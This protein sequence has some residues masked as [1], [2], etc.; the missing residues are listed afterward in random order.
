MISTNHAAVVS[1][2]FYG[3]PAMGDNYSAS[4]PAGTQ[5]ATGVTHDNKTVSALPDAQPYL[6]QLPAEIKVIV[7]NHLSFRDIAAL[8]QTCTMLYTFMEEK[9]IA[10]RKCFTHHLTPT[11]QESFRVAANL[12]TLQEFTA[13]L[14]R[15]SDDQ[16]FI[17]YALSVHGNQYFP[18]FLFFLMMQFTIN[19]RFLEITAT[20]SIEYSNAAV[21]YGSFS[22]NGRHILTT[23]SSSGMIHSVNDQGQWEMKMTIPSTSTP[24]SEPSF[25]ANSRHV[26]TAGHPH[27]LTTTGWKYPIEIYDFSDDGK[28][29]KAIA[30]PHCWE[31]RCLSATFFNKS[32]NI[33]LVSGD[34]EKKLTIYGM[35]N[36]GNWSPDPVSSQ[37]FWVQKIAHSPDGLHGVTFQ[38]HQWQ[39]DME[40]STIGFFAISGSDWRMRNEF[41]CKYVYKLVFS[42]DNRHMVAVHPKKAKIYGIDSNGQWEL[43]K[44]IRHKYGDGG[45]HNSRYFHYYPSFHWATFSP[46]GRYLATASMH[47]QKVKISGLHS[48]SYQWYDIT[49]INH[50]SDVNMVAFS[51]DSRHLV[52]GSDDCSAKLYGL[53]AIDRWYLKKTLSHNDAVMCADFS[54]DGSHLVTGCCNGQ[55]KLYGM[56]ADR[57]WV[58]KGMVWS[59]SSETDFKR[60]SSV[61]FSPCGFQILVGSAYGLATLYTLDDAQL[62]GLHV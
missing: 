8:S 9:K 27:N 38:H 48:D 26:V 17:E 57:T 56:L 14:R 7:C 54:P 60:I 32:Q 34:D 41:D 20:K 53:E 11:S 47:C 44:T 51:S 42:P 35:D 61:K 62:K 55:I 36:N 12:L 16:Q 3:E 50:D 23:N 15:F 59:K 49:T 33:T 43:K 52:T 6:L 46:N 2:Q 28:W 18:E 25:S 39:E 19:C 58:E 45:H 37:K 40:F 21:V 10:C 13:W 30:I 31:S 24:G 1:D 4:H 29:T 5:Y 22:P